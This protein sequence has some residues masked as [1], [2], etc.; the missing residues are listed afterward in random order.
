MSGVGAPG[1]LE[2]WGCCPRGSGSSFALAW[3]RERHRSAPF[4]VPDPWVL[5]GNPI[6]A[7]S[8]QLRRSCGQAILTSVGG[9]S[10]RSR[11][12]A[13]PP[14]SPRPGRPSASSLQPRLFQLLLARCPPG[15]LGGRWQGAGSAPTTGDREPP[16]GRQVRVPQACISA[17]R[18]QRQVKQVHTGHA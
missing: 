13:G 11:S 3:D 8:P 6:R 14:A 7:G 9:A 12:P 2:P 5:R 16:R 10:E 18:G 17:S 15:P 1:A 4:P